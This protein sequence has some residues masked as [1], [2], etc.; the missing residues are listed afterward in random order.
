[1]ENFP[2]VISVEQDYPSI[3]SKQTAINPVD[4]ATLLLLINPDPVGQ[5]MSLIQAVRE[6][7]LGPQVSGQ[8]KQLWP[9]TSPRST[10]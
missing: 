10:H 9:E 2:T 8:E 3:S 7:P 1:M 5:S 4:P 6:T